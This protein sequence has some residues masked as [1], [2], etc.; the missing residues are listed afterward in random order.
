MLRKELTTPGITSASISYNTIN[1]SQSVLQIQ[2]RRA[3]VF[4]DMS[5]SY[6]YHLLS[7]AVNQDLR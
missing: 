5:N 3:E 4:Q 1:Q 2:F 7:H 6:V